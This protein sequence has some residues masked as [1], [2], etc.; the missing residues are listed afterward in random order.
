MK[1]FDDLDD[2]DDETRAA[3]NDPDLDLITDYVG[4]EL[5]PDQVE[6]VLRRLE[7]DEKFREFAAPILVA[8]GVAPHWQRFP[9]PRSEI[10]AGWDDFTR[11]A[12]FAHQ[13]RRARRRRLWLLG[14]LL[15]ALALPSLLYSKEIRTAYREWRDYEVVRGDTGWVTLRDGTRVQLAPG[16][17]LL[18]SKQRI[19]GVQQL[20]LEG[21][22]RFSAFPTDTL[23]PAP[24]LQPL[25]VRTRGGEAFTGTAE[26]TVTARGDT[27]DVA[28]HRP[29]T[30]R[31]FGFVP[32]RTAVLVNTIADENPVSLGETQSA[33]LIRDGRVERTRP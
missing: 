32:V 23:G 30:R 4:G 11:R 17:R 25:L 5:D 15:A 3:L 2:L 12:G 26:F 33:R 27:T 7:Q 8:W 28:V 14:L 1:K 6:A 18:S 29:A 22:A 31:F 24:A 10:E 21:T 9:M 13:K 20:R 16:A 19:R